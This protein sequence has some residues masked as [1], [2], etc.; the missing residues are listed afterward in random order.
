MELMALFTDSSLN[1][2]N[3]A[4]VGAC[5]IVSAF[6]L[7]TPPSEIKFSELSGLLKVRRFEE[8]SS[9]ALELRTVLW[10]V[11]EYKKSFSGWGNLRLYSDSKCVADLL[12]RRPGLEDKYFLSGTTNRLLKN[13]LLYRKFYEFHDELV[14]EII[15]VKGHGPSSSLAKSGTRDAHRGCRLWPGHA[16]LRRFGIILA[17]DGRP[18]A[19]R[20]GVS[21][22]RV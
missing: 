16:A 6:F 10:A 20:L 21:E 8:T 14:F 7:D 4:G 17:L 12:K 2:D 15:K 22:Q 1:L 9:A 5:F 3:K 13:A 11:E 19:D 18:R